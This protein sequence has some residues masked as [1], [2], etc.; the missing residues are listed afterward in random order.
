[1]PPQTRAD[2]LFG[3]KPRA[4]APTVES[5][6]ATVR[7]RSGASRRSARARNA[8]FPQAGNNGARGDETA[9]DD[10]FR[11][12]RLSY[13]DRRALRREQRIVARTGRD[14]ENI[15]IPNRETAPRE[16]FNR[17]APRE[18]PRETTNRDNREAAPRERENRDRGN[19]EPREGRDNRDNRDGNR[20]NR[21]G[22]RDGGNRDGG[23]RERDNGRDT[24]REA[25]DT[26][27]EPREPREP[28]FPNGGGRR[29]EY[30]LPALEAMDAE[31][32]QNV[33]AELN[34]EEAPGEKSPLIYAIL[35]A[36]AASQ[37]AILKKG[38]LEISPDQKGFLRCENYYPS[39][40]DVYVS[41][42]QIKRFGLKTGDEVLGT[43][44]VPKENERYHGLLRVESINGL[45]IE[46]SR[47][48]RDFDKLTPIFP[49]ERFDLEN[50]TRQHHRPHH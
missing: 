45:S 18:T 5:S 44:R 34:M 27:R 22:N 40:G 19:R 16:N 15:E 50:R 11:N 8:G 49:T 25:R 33:V 1:M 24:R 6:G 31:T 10:D 38:I 23:N 43:A 17:E 26:R 30:D 41:Q 21:D 42:T 2:S 7:A 47:E 9:D 37:N 29:R 39:E 46:A 48:R 3:P 20:S 13:R 4:Q 36:Q 14:D 12:G 28:A 32:L 35:E